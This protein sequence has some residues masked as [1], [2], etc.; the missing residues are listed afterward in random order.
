MKR[1]MMRNYD[2]KD[3]IR[4]KKLGKRKY[5]MQIDYWFLFSFFF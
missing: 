2:Y 1:K 4:Q 5:Q 3:I